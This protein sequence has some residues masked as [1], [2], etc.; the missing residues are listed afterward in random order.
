MEPWPSGGT[1]R[2]EQFHHSLRLRLSVEATQA[3]RRIKT[4]FMCHMHCCL[5]RRLKEP[6]CAKA[7]VFL[8]QGT[9]LAALR[10]VHLQAVEGKPAQT[11]D[12]DAIKSKQE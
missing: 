8:E 1:C 7:D 3:R 10:E 6:S 9:W 5:C 4:L 12:A 2:I 11:M